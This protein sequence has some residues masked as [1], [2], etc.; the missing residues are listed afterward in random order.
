MCSSRQLW[1][2]DAGRTWHET[3]TIGPKFTAGGGGD[4]YFWTGGTLRRLG[5]FPRTTSSVHLT[6]H[7]VTSFN[8]G[9]IV[10]VE[11]TPTGV[12]AL[13]S[14]RVHGQRWDSAPRVLV[15]R[16]GVAQTAQLPTIRGRFLATSLHVSWPNLTVSG[17]D[18]V[19]DPARAVTWTSDD[20]GVTWTT[21]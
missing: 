17:T 18:F 1:T 13:V 8:D 21:P 10:D 3:E 11:P 5:S 7:V 6:S 19:A 20:G 4:V 14:S 15:M 9:T 16:G 12:A 2:N